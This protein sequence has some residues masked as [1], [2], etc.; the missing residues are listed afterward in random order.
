MKQ[1][2][3]STNGQ[4]QSELRFILVNGLLKKGMFFAVLWFLVSYLVHFD[5]LGFW[6]LVSVSIILGLFTVWVW[7]FLVGIKPRETPNSFFDN[8]S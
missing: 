8:F 6:D 5:S 7:G 3:Q 4:Q 1:T 2:I